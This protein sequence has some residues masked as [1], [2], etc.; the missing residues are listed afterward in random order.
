MIK[1][2]DLRTESSIDFYLCANKQEFL[3][4]DGKKCDTEFKYVPVYANS[5]LIIYE[6]L[7]RDQSVFT[8]KVIDMKN[9]RTLSVLKN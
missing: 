4:K 3:T 1:R 7:K 9:R 2:F 6:G 8:I 5:W